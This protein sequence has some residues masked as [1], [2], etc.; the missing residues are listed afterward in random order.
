MR[1]LVTRAEPA[2]SR[3]RHK[4]E[5]LGHEPYVLPI[6]ELKDLGGVLPDYPYDGIIFT[7]ANAV[8][9]LLRRNW[10][11]HNPDT[12]AYCVGKRTEEAAEQIGF[13]RTIAASGGG[14]ALVL[15]FEKLNLPEN[16][17]F[18]YP[19]TPDR[20]F[21]MQLALQKKG[22]SVD[23]VE[24]YQTRKCNRAGQELSGAIDWCKDGAVLAYS[25][26]SAEYLS[27]LLS[28]LND[29]SSISSISLIGI[30]KTATNIM[31]KY[32]WRDVYVS[33]NPS[34]DD[35]LILLQSLASA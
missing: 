8:E 17:R 27:E 11:N 19:T 34:E 9:V 35:M 4:L 28:S 7:S 16:Q 32:P 5:K 13:S 6:F 3:T 21:D 29:L 33:S 26:R 12:V 22:Y 20:S 18:L 14:A 1:V 15:E 24:L 2:A 30:S 23:L 31:L 25:A 10:R